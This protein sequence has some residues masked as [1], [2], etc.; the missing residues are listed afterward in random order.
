MRRQTFHHL[1]TISKNGDKHLET[2][3]IGLQGNIF[4][5]SLY[6]GGHFLFPDSLAYTDARKFWPDRRLR[7]RIRFW[8]FIWH[9]ESETM[10]NH[11]KGDE[12]KNENLRPSQGRQN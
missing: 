7:T 6:G 10:K 2:H 11:K 4:F 3:S 1:K 12:I 5:I 9:D 8:T